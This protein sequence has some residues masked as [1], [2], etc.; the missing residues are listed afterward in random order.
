MI[1]TQKVDA[2]LIIL[3]L[4]SGMLFAQLLCRSQQVAVK[5][6]PLF[7]VMAFCF[8]SLFNWT[9]HLVAVSYVNVKLI[10]Q[11]SFVY[12]FRFYSLMLM[13]V[14]FLLLILQQ[15]RCILSM[16]RGDASG[17]Q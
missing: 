14:V 13:G 1:D 11:G 15:L 10:L 5:R 12:S 3:S 9:G 8:W 16:L 17:Y 4:L 6:L 7:L 2:A